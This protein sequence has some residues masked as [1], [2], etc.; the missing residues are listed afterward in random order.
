[1][2]TAGFKSI[3]VS[4]YIYDK[5]SE[6]FELNKDNLN[7]KGITSLSGYVTENLDKF[8]TNHYIEAKHPPRFTNISIDE[9]IVVFLDNI[10]GRII[11][12]LNSN[13]ILKC[14]FCNS[15]KC[16]HIGFCYSLHKLYGT[17]WK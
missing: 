10:L 1:M 8:I 3:T 16:L 12:I 7:M 9:K 6:V 2:P 4:D 15:E 11:E 13:G 17:V 14:T 5:I